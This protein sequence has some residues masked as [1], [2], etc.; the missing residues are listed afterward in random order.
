MNILQNYE[1]T[2]L[3]FLS[4]YCSN[5][6]YSCDCYGISVG[7]GYKTSAEVVL[8]EILQ[9]EQKTFVITHE[10]KDSIQSHYDRLVSNDTIHF[11]EYTIQ[12]IK[13]YK[14]TQ[15]LSELI[16]RAEANGSNCDVRLE[17]GSTYMLYGHNNWWT[18]LYYPKDKYFVLSSICT[19]TTS[20]WRKEQK[21]LEK[22][23]RKMTKKQKHKI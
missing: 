3:I 19:R 22:Y 16:I 15:D 18:N 11:V 6:A 12:I 13:S 17:V 7:E 10:S 5:Y 9:A 20:R 1:H 14:S 2:I 8:G 23:L 4:L 21:D